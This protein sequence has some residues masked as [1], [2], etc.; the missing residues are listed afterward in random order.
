M[1]EWIVRLPFQRPP[2]SENYR[3]H[4][5]KRNRIVND[6]KDAAHTMA[7]ATRLPKGLERVR[8]ELHW[9]PHVMRQRDTDNPTP[10]L[11]AAIDGLVRYGLVADDNSAHVTSTVVIEPLGPKPALWLIIQE[12]Q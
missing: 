10:T 4:W 9:Q 7:V 11:K 1:N 12:E 3:L 2:L 6:V 8:I 5:A